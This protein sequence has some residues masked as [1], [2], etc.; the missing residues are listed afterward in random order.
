MITKPHLSQIQSTD[1]NEHPHLLSEMLEILGNINDLDGKGVKGIFNSYAKMEV[2]AEEIGFYKVIIDETLNN[3]P[4]GYYFDGT[5]FHIK[6][7][8]K[9]IIDRIEQV[10]DVTKD[11]VELVLPKVDLDKIK[12]VVVKPNQTIIEIPL[13]KE[14]YEYIGVIVVDGVAVVDISIIGDKIVIITEEAQPS[15]EIRITIPEGSIKSE[16][17]KF[18]K[19]VELE[20]I[21]EG[22]VPT[23][24][25]NS[26]NG[27]VLD[28]EGDQEFRFKITYP[29]PPKTSTV[30]LNLIHCTQSF[31]RELDVDTDEL[32][33][34]L[35]LV[36]GREYKIIFYEGVVDSDNTPSN[37]LECSFKV[38]EETV[39]VLPEEPIG[40]GE[41]E[42]T[43]TLPNAS[44]MYDLNTDSNFI[45][46][47][48]DDLDIYGDEYIL[49]YIGYSGDDEPKVVP[50]IG[51]DSFRSSNP[52]GGYTYMSGILFFETASIGNKVY[53][54]IKLGGGVSG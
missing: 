41:W 54:L 10:E 17:G 2:G 50:R 8:L 12:D 23:I 51:F 47:I 48:P 46:E 26:V 3:H 14:G 20:L 44:S 25:Q 4:T 36:R 49:Q 16:S 11:T 43:F 21:V 53:R 1:N 6:Y 39:P 37:Y 34:K 32:I 27:T 5:N 15:T 45:E 31:N 35:D 29:T 9:S 7:G 19:Q 28:L 22:E 13:D 38:K 18:N 40:G 24:Q 33:V 30:D 42:Y 52:D